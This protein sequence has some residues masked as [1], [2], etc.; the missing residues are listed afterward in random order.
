MLAE[1]ALDPD[2]QGD[3]RGRAAYARA[4]ETDTDKVVRGDFD[5][6]DIA[7]VGLD[8]WADEVDDHCDALG[9]RLRDGAGRGLRLR[10]IVDRAGGDGGA[11]AGHDS[12]W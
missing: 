5:Q 2:L 4:V 8:G 1:V 11:K 3:R 7:A 10:R 9:E 12:E 6:F